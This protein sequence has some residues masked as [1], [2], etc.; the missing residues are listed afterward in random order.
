MIF[1]T[2][3]QLDMVA[4]D[5]VKFVHRVATDKKATPEEIAVLPEIVK[6]LCENI[7]D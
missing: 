4:E 2:K 1:A 3:E 6:V 7:A 5:L